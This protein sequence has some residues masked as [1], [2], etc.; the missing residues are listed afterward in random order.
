MSKRNTWRSFL[1]SQAICYRLEGL[2]SQVYVCRWMSR[3]RVG[4]VSCFMNRN[5]KSSYWLIWEVSM[6]RSF[7]SGKVSWSDPIIP[8]SEFISKMLPLTSMP[9]E[10]S[11]LK[12]VPIT[13]QVTNS[14][15]IKW[16][17]SKNKIGSFLYDGL[18]FVFSFMSQICRYLLFI[19]WMN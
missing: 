2:Q 4:I 19:W 3:L 17:W 1:S 9:K 11:P 18:L 5:W 14:S 10:R 7:R 16:T 12:S 6:E 13:I 15:K 8:T